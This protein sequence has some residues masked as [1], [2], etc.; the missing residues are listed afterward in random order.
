VSYDRGVWLL[1]TGAKLDMEPRW[2]DLVLFYEF[3]NPDTG[4]GHGARSVS[5]YLCRNK[6]CY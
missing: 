2:R 5:V 1:D 4:R 3:Y 6:S